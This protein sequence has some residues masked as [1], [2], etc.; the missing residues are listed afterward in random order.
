MLKKALR[1]D[2][3]ETKTYFR[4]FR[5]RSLKGGN[6]DTGH[7]AGVNVTCANRE[8]FEIVNFDV[9][10]AQLIGTQDSN[11]PQTRG[12]PKGRN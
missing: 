4:Q 2:A 10:V 8:H 5:A 1:E 6:A 12:R 9:G 7:N 3:A 11:Y